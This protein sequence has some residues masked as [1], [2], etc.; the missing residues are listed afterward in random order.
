M[1]KFVPFTCINNCSIKLLLQLTRI[2]K[3]KINYGIKR[4]KSIWQPNKLADYDKIN[5]TDIISQVSFIHNEI[6]AQNL[7]TQQHMQEKAKC[8]R[9]KS[10]PRFQRSRSL[11]KVEAF[12]ERE[13]PRF[14]SFS[15]YLGA[16]NKVCACSRTGAIPIACRRWG[17]KVVVKTTTFN[18]LTAHQTAQ[19]LEVTVDP[20]QRWVVCNLATNTCSKCNHTFTFLP[21][22]SLVLIKSSSLFCND[23]VCRAPSL[24]SPDLLE[25][26]DPSFHLRRASA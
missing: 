2:T 5:K 13:F 15:S 20:I 25:T 14:H 17:E 18:Q 22:Q 19:V 23:I 11:R 7:A 3:P 24:P 4:G 21:R 12:G 10:E 16:R 26:G 8:K 1:H 9:V 6:Q